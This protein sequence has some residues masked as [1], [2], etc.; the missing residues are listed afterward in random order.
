MGKFISMEKIEAM[1]FDELE[2]VAWD[3]YGISL[4]HLGTTSR[5]EVERHKVI[6]KIRER[7]NRKGMFIIGIAVLFITSLALIIAIYST[8]IRV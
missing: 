8:F 5:D 3:Y 6:N 7:R 4:R 1:N 2:P